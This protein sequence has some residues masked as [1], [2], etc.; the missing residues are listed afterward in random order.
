MTA[1]KFV[2]L[3]GRVIPS[4]SL[5]LSMTLRFVPQFRAQF[6]QVREAQR[7]IG[8]DMANGRL[9]QRLRHAFRIFSIMLSRTMENAIETADSMKGRGYGLPGRTAFSVYRFD[10]RDGWMLAGILLA[11]AYVGAGCLSG[12]LT[13]WYFPTVGGALGGGYAVSVYAV[14]GGL[15]F[16]PTMWH[17]REARQWRLLRSNI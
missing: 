2:Y 10:K 1:E 4:L 7:C 17:V 6:R 14:Y 8:R 12:T 9:L 16:F 13:F 3:F 15:C 5:V 11:A